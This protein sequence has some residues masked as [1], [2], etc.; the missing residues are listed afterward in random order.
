M[1]FDNLYRLP[2]VGC[3][4]TNLPALV[5]FQQLPQPTPNYVVVISQHYSDHRFPPGISHQSPGCLVL[6]SSFPTEPTP[7]T[8]ESGPLSGY[9]NTGWNNCH[10]IDSGQCTRCTRHSQ[11]RTSARFPILRL[12]LRP[13]YQDR[14]SREDKG[15]TARTG[16]NAAVPGLLPRRLCVAAPIKPSFSKKTM[17]FFHGSKSTPPP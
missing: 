15:L 16:R 1:L 6:L 17:P 3:F 11:L 14:I 5:F 9:A 8:K 13:R 2:S 7:S 4:P 12:R 10:E